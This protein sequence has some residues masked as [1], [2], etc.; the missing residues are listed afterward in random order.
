MILNYRNS[1]ENEKKEN[2]KIKEEFETLRTQFEG[3]RRNFNSDLEKEFI[4]NM[5]YFEYLK[6]QE[7][8]LLNTR[9]FL[10]HKKNTLEHPVEDMICKNTKVENLVN[11]LEI[12]IQENHKLVEAIQRKG[13]TFEQY[14]L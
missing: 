4:E 1:L 8:N 3:L 6:H 11:K 9:E 14:L 10:I 13:K 5:V 12:L 7:N 2:A